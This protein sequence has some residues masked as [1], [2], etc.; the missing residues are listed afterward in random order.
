[1]EECVQIRRIEARDR[2]LLVYLQA[3]TIALTTVGSFIII[4]ALISAAVIPQPPNETRQPAQVSLHCSSRPNVA[5]RTLKY[6]DSKTE[7]ML[8][9]VERFFQRH[10]SLGVRSLEVLKNKVC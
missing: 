2:A 9:P 10:T 5:G 1:M 8:Q 4:E 6:L 7:K 3:L